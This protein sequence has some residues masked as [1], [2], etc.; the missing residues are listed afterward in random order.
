[1]IGPHVLRE[2]TA[3]AERLVASID[4]A[5]QRGGHGRQGGAVLTPH[6]Q[7][8]GRVLLLSG[9]RRDNRGGA[10]QARVAEVLVS[11]EGGAGVEGE[12]A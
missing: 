10:R 2:G 1:M 6:R 11:L 4:G 12:T 3:A 5:H 8:M 9:R 7:V